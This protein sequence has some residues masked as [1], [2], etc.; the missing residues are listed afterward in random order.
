M[1]SYIFILVALLSLLLVPA[2]AVNFGSVLI[3]GARSAAA[4]ARLGQWKGRATWNCHR[5]LHL[6]PSAKRENAPLR[7]SVSASLAAW[8]M[9]WAVWS[10]ASSCRSLL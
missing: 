3:R 7:L 8:S 4:N 5:L 10:V 2:P 1:R 9:Y 6:T